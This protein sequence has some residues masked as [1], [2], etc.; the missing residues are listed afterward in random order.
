MPRPPAVKLVHPPART[1]AIATLSTPAKVVATAA[2]EL[3]YGARFL[4]WHGW[5][6]LL[7]FVA[8]LLP[9]LAF[10]GLAGELREDGGFFFDMPV[11]VALHKL[12]TPGVDAF[13]VGMS[14]LGYQ[15]G[16]IPAD[17]LILYALVWQRRYRDGLFF[18]LSV[19]GSLV[20][21]LA[22]K[23]HFA[24]TRPD[25]W[26]PISPEMTFSF[27]SGHAMGSMTLGVALVLL[28]WNTRWR[29]WALAGM[30][31]FVALVGTSRIYLGVHFPSDILA[32]WSAAAAWVF[33]MHW[34]VAGHAPP[35]PK[36]GKAPA[37]PDLIARSATAKKAKGAAR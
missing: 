26:T 16:V 22:A 30:T 20:I 35:P 31:S 37:K 10:G 1:A 32:G 33:A 2:S 12:A 11:L 13:F 15:W 5:R 3:G 8:I 25:L 29:W 24:R 23:N 18:G 28:L 27:P 7:G 21:N 9:L 19:I 17:V 36:G 34:A 4:R 6:L 14:K